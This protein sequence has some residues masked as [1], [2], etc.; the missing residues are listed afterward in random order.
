MCLSVQKKFFPSL[1]NL[2]VETALVFLARLARAMIYIVSESQTKIKG[3]APM[4]PVTT[5]FRLGSTPSETMLSVWPF[6]YEF[7]PVPMNFC[8]N[9]LTFITTPMAAAGKII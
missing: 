6:A 3:L 1:E 9:V 4:E 8:F 5:L 7:T 2:I